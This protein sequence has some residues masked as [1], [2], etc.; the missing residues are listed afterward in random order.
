MEGF[1]IIQINNI[2]SKAWIISIEKFV[3]PQFVS[4]FFSFDFMIYRY[5]SKYN[6]KQKKLGNQ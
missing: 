1:T 3:I 4:L 6:F 2:I 5:A